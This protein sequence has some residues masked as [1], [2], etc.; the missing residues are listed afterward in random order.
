MDILKQSEQ[1]GYELVIRW[2]QNVNFI[3]SD[4]G[5]QLCRKIST[6]FFRDAHKW[7]INVWGL[8]YFSKEKWE[9]EKIFLKR[10]KILRNVKSWER[11][12]ES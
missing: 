4:T 1:L 6:Y 2:I 8:N 7:K 12:L 10:G 5:V 11:V 9:K 3:R